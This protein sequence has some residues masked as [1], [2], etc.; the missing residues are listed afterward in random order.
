M[1]SQEMI[2]QYVSC[3]HFIL[4]TDI[5]LKACRNETWQILLLVKQYESQAKWYKHNKQFY[6]LHDF[7]D[8]SY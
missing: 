3:K 8:H 1:M 2:K 7:T 4:T 5:R 6:E